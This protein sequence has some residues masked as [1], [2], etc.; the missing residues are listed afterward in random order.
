MK[1]DTIDFRK[2]VCSEISKL[3][4][5]FRRSIACK[6]PDEGGGDRFIRTLFNAGIP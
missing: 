1:V 4:L 5:A 2:S 3:I 6:S